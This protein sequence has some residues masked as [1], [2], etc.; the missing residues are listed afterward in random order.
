M[1]NFSIKAEKEEEIVRNLKEQMEN[2]LE[3]EGREHET[4]IDD[5]IE[6]STEAMTSSMQA[7]SKKAKNNSDKNK[8]MIT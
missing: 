2:D 8:K 4:R 1:R 5:I 3:F 7:I 6:K